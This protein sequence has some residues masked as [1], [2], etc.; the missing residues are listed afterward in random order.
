MF[1]VVI[2]R[3]TRAFKEFSFSIFL[4]SSKIAPPGRPSKNLSIQLPFHE[5]FNWN[6]SVPGNYNLHF[7]QKNPNF[8]EKP[9][10][11]KGIIDTLT[12]SLSLHLVEVLLKYIFYFTLLR[13]E[14]S[15]HFHL[16]SKSMIEQKQQKIGQ[17][18][19]MQNSWRRQQRQNYKIVA[20]EK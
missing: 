14:Y 9:L 5:L 2:K 11:F 19:F 6:F 15:L 13:Q 8:S 3:R 16:T 12:L 18:R 7:N 1:G 10:A 4:T 20:D 17:A